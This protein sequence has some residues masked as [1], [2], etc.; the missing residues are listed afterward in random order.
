MSITRT[1]S[2]KAPAGVRAPW[3]TELMAA[4]AAVAAGLLG[5]LLLVPLGG[6]EIAANMGGAVKTV[7][8]LDIAIT[9][10]GAG[11]IG[12]LAL[13]VLE[14]LTARALTVW[15]VVAVAVLAVSFV[16]PAMAV[17]TPAMWALVGLHVLVAGAVIAVGRWSRR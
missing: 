1:Q 4:G 16:G 3:T 15:T 6:I 17:S 10:F 5:W 2:V 8:A 11:V 12:L 7:G 14:R 9:A 13:R